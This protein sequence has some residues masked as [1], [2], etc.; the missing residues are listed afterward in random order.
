MGGC[1]VCADE[2]EGEG[3]VRADVGLVG[4]RVQG[5]EDGVWGVG[6]VGLWR[7][8]CAVSFVVRDVE[9]VDARCS[10]ACPV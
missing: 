8:E 9:S 7:V 2:A 3:G 4:W 6:D 5:V 1:D 10:C